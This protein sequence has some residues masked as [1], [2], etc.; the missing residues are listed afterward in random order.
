MAPHAVEQPIRVLWEGLSGNPRAVLIVGISVTSVITAALVESPATSLILWP[1]LFISAILAGYHY[2]EKGIIAATLLGLASLGVGSLRAYPETAAPIFAA[3]LPF[4]GMIALASIASTLGYSTRERARRREG[5]VRGPGGAFLLRRKDGAI[6]D[7]NREFAE[8][9][10]YTHDELK[11]MP[12]SRIWPCTED[13]KRFIAMAEPGEQVAVIETQ[14]LD[15]NGVSRWFAISGLCLDRATVACRISEITRYK[16][17]EA[18]LNAERSRL[19][20]V[21]DT[22]P[23]YVTLQGEDHMFQFVNRAFRET[24]GEPEGRPCYM[25][26]QAS[27]VPCD[28]CRGSLVFSHKIPQQWTWRHSDGR[29]YEVHAYPF[30]DTDGSNLMLQLG[31]EI[32][33]RVQTEKALEEFAKNLQAKNQELEMLRDELS[34]INRDLDAAVRERTADVERLLDQ[35]NEFISQLGHDLKAPLVSLVALMPR[36]LQLEQDPALRRLL[37]IIGGNVNYMKDL[38][39]KTLKLARMNTSNI[40]LELEALNL[41]TELNTILRNYTVPFGAKAIT[42]DTS[43]PAEI[44]VR[45][46]R[47]LLTEVFDN[48]IANAVRG[49]P[50]GTGTISITA[51]R[52]RGVVIVAVSNTGAGLTRDQFERVFDEVFTADSSHRDLET[53]GLDL[54]ICRRIVE[55]HGGQVWAWN[56]GDGS[57]SAILFALEAAEDV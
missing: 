32:T 55:R 8:A 49:M 53:P 36:I 24:F 27:L 12:I 1:L 18:I 3:L 35:K 42:V 19:F 29:V 28:P 38:V 10:G 15:R 41:R 7:A 47:V 48:L 21:L 44:T 46:D 52:D 56:A 37:G 23:A 33:G 25:V 50:N 22:L 13:R 54:A 43:I 11:N 39:E 57:G 20:S 45:A 51:A 31:V 17:M 26:Q 5:M 4:V 16:E 34:T 9:L 2:H 40:E 14:F 30:T 6:A